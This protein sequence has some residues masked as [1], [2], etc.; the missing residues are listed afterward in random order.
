MLENS[1][2]FLAGTLHI[3]IALIAVVY[4]L[5]ASKYHKL[6]LMVLGA[7]TLPMAYI[8]GKVLGLY[9]VTVRPFVAMDVQPLV[10]HAADNGF[11]SEHTLY[12]MIIAGVIWSVHKKL[13]VC[14]G[15]LALIVGV[16]RVLALV[17]NPVDILGSIIIAI[18]VLYILLGTKVTTLVNMLID[19]TGGYL[20]KIHGTIVQK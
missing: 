9:I 4:F 7:I 6:K 13:G 14:L 17:H 3:I 11:P 15:L 18:V 20:E 19:I 12:A 10:E 1:I 2:I 5:F 8:T 16:A